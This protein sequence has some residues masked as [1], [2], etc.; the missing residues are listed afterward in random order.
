LQFTSGNSISDRFAVLV[1][2]SGAIALVLLPIQNFQ[3]V[4]NI[5][6]DRSPT[7]IIPQLRQLLA[8]QLIMANCLQQRFAIA[9]GYCFG[10]YLTLEVVKGLYK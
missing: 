8:Y 6:G 4:E 7:T 2:K 5:R 1:V 10:S 9:L 3:Q